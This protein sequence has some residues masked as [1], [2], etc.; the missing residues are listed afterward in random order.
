MS[1]RRRD[2]HP[3]RVLTRNEVLA[4]PM[5]AVVWEEF[6][7]DDE[8]G[9]GCDLYPCVVFR[10]EFGAQMIS[11]DCCK[12]IGAQMLRYAPGELARWWTAMPT[13]EQRVWEGTWTA[14]GGAE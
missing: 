11:R 3:A 10:D 14:E 5:G 2:P 1:G 4:L 13:D 12:N 6:A 7:W 9:K 8:S